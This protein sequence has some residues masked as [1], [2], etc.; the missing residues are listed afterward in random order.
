MSTRQGGP[1]PRRSRPRRSPCPWVPKSPRP[2]PP[3]RRRRASRRIPSPKRR[4]RG[5]PRLRTLRVKHRTHPR[6]PATWTCSS[7]ARFRLD[8]EDWFQAGFRPRPAL[9]RK[10]PRAFDREA[11]L[12]RLAKLRTMTYGWD[13]RWA[14]LKLPAALSPEEAHFWLVA[15]SEPRGAIS[16][17]RPLRRPSARRGRSMER[18]RSTTRSSRP[19]GPN[20]DW[21]T[22]CPSRWRTSCLPRISSK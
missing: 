15:M 11:C 22:R 13:V 20:G 1:W 2:L 8:P 3:G 10:P 14:D 7:I 21:R 4:P 9:E 5:P 12:E 17:C 6:R 16:R 18:S 19:I